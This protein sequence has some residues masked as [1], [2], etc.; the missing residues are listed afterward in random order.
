MA[1]LTTK[2]TE[3]ITTKKL[4]AVDRKKLIDDIINYHEPAFEL[5]DIEQATQFYPKVSFM[6]SDEPHISLFKKEISEPY[7][8]IELVNEDYTPKDSNRSLYRFRGSPECINEYFGKKEVGN[9]GEY[10]RYFVPLQDFERIDLNSLL[11]TNTKTINSLQVKQQPVISEPLVFEE[12]YDDQEET[13]ALM[14]KLTIRDH[15]A[16]QWKLPVSNKKWLNNLI[17]QVN[18]I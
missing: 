13:D 17:K 3:M 4:T 12:T 10:F 16:I 14:A 1:K 7:F 15:A 18:K 8:Y 9:F 2:N 11:Q 5:L 6:W